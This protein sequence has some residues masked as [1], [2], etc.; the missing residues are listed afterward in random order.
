MMKHSTIG[1][2]GGLA[3]SDLER[4][5]SDADGRT[6][7]AIVWTAG[8]AITGIVGGALYLVIVR[9]DAILLDLSALSKYVFCF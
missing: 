8:M 7:R 1:R 2:V 5:R 9:G 6:P 4:D 3:R